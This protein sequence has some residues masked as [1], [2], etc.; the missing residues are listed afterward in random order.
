MAR[1]N[2]VF[3]IIAV[4]NNTA[5]LGVGNTKD[6]LAVNQFGIFDY[7]TNLSIDAATA[8][9]TRNW[10]MALAVDRDG[11]GLVDDYVESAG[12]HIQ[13]GNIVGY[14]VRS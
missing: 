9:T 10:Y 4:P 1:N 8:A 14:T 3:S 6:S 7:E 2:D 12:T 5:I 13:K 11:D